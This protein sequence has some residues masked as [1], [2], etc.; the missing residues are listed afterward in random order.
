[1]IESVG[2]SSQSC[3]VQSIPGRRMVPGRRIGVRLLSVTMTFVA[4]TFGVA[5]DE[6]SKPPI[7]F[8]HCQLAVTDSEGNPVDDATIRP[9]GFRT[10]VERGSHWAWVE[11][12]HG[13]VPVTHTDEDGRATIRVPKHVTEKLVIGE[14]SWVVDHP[15]F[16]TY[17]GDHNVVDAPSIV[18]LG[19]GYRIAATVVDSESGK[20]ITEDIYGV[21]SGSRRTP[22]EWTLAKNG[23]LVSSV[24]DLE[25][26]KLRVVHL[27][28][29]QPARFSKLID[30]QAPDGS[31]RAFLRE[32]SV[33]PGTRV[34]GELAAQVPRPVKRGH[35]T[36]FISAGPDTPNATRNEHW[37]WYDKADVQE[38]GTFVFQSLPRGEVVQ[39][40][41]VCDGWLSREPTL[42]EIDVTAPWVKKVAGQMGRG[43]CAPL[44]Y[45]LNEPTL[46]LKIGMTRTATCEVTVLGPDGSPLPNA[47]VGMWPN[48]RWLRGGSTIV[49]VGIR[50]SDML[51]SHRGRD[52]I[53]WIALLDRFSARS[54]E[55]GVATIVNLPGK[56]NIG[57][58]VEHDEFEQPIANRDRSTN[59]TLKSGETHR[60][61]I[62][63][64]PKGTEVLGQ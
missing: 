5:A 29:D 59:V 40:I 32:V 21:M 38:D 2:L 35:V 22:S 64:Q 63:M 4:C 60:L 16:V 44:V 34:E 37:N 36:A 20:T 45:M 30:V 52:D 19:N 50:S 39:L 11:D 43:T 15:D 31:D 51:R 56:P 42:Q 47:R 6:S 14:V 33:E 61:Q 49:G 1:M 27:P 25:R 18:E 54:N 57:L 12:R 24:I 41:A 8:I 55:Q 10:V 3:C 62:K 7:E 23:T 48:Q 17:Y 53:D 58:G 46:R 28:D 13:P 9:I 26:T